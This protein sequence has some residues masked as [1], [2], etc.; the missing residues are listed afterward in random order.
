MSE[1]GFCE[2]LAPVP[3]FPGRCACGGRIPTREEARSYWDK[4]VAAGTAQ[5]PESMHQSL[6]SLIAG[7]PW[8]RRW[9]TRAFS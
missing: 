2:C 6:L 5:N 7:R 8:Q 9:T 1:G 3:G 4:R